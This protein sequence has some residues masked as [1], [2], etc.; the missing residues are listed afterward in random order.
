[1]DSWKCMS[2]ERGIYLSEEFD[3]EYGENHGYSKGK[4]VGCGPK[5]SLNVETNPFERLDLV[6][7]VF[8]DET[9]EELFSDEIGP[10][11]GNGNVASPSNNNMLSTVD[12]TVGGGVGDGGVGTDGE[13]REAGLFDGASVQVKR[14]RSMS[15]FVQSPRCQVLGCNKDLVTYKGY[16]K[17]HKVCEEH[18]RTSRVTVNG[19]EQRFCQQCSRFHQLAEFDDNKRSCRKRLA[20]HNKRRRKPRFLSEPGTG[21]IDFSSSYAFSESLPA[22]TTSLNE[23]EE[24]KWAEHVKIEDSIGSSDISFHTSG[25]TDIT[26]DIPTHVIDNIIST[27]T[28]S[29]LNSASVQQPSRAL[30]LLSAQ[31]CDT[32]SNL[33]HAH[34]GVQDIFKFKDTTQICDSGKYLVEADNMDHIMSAHNECATVDPHLPGDGILMESE[35]RN[36]PLGRGIILDLLQL[37]SR[38]QSIE[39]QKLSSESEAG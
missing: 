34:N 7:M 33:G 21:N 23:I 29:I 5:V 27:P 32:D 22:A 35:I 18:T 15:S 25:V 20:V 16:Y 39:Q 8:S 26:K 17:R 30:S 13:L 12:F 10:D 4:L 31:S 28:C 14:S 9:S 11:S 38:L 3:F 2:E 24:W 6:N 1:M 36:S 19:M 37:S